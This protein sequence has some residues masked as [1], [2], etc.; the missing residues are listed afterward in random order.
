MLK[1]KH[2]LFDLDHTLWDFEK[3]ATET[4]SELYEI[5]QL[6][7]LGNFSMQEFCQTFHKINYHLWELHQTG[8][9]DQVSLRANRFKMIFTE[10][11]VAEEQVPL[12]IKDE[13][14]RICPSKPHVFP[15]AHDVLAYLQSRYQLHIVTNGFADVQ[16]TKLKSAGLAHYFTHIVTSDGA[17]FCKPNPA[18]FYHVLKLVGAKASEC[19]MVG[20]NLLTD[21]AGAQNANIDCIYFNPQ[22]IPHEASRTHEICNLNELK[23]IL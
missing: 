22:K 18:I 23:G 15:F 6:K 16:E 10:L 14:L 3:N 1:Y 13:Y 19:I 7:A 21:I 11:G 5:F 4:L 12:T 8:E 20:D 2:I 9:Y 17:N